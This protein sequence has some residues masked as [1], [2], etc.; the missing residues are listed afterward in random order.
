[1]KTPKLRLKVLSGEGGKRGEYQ[2]E[3]GRLKDERK[4]PSLGGSDVFVPGWGTLAR[5][6][7]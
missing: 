6:G 4:Y 1:L 5:G 7:S 2:E 3:R